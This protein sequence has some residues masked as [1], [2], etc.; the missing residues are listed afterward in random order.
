MVSLDSAPRLIRKRWA[1]FARCCA[2]SS[3][4]ASVS[5]ATIAADSAVDPTVT[6]LVQGYMSLNTPDI[7]LVNALTSPDLCTSGQNHCLQVICPEGG[8]RK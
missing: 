8:P 1:R 4:G 5:P 2:D 3:Q 6:G 7:E